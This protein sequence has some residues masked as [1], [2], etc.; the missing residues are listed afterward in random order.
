MHYRAITF[1][2]LTD[3]RNT[4]LRIRGHIYLLQRA[5]SAAVLQYLL[6]SGHLVIHG[7]TSAI[8]P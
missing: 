4:Y 8:C 7:V 3:T 6:P 5:L 1:T 2:G